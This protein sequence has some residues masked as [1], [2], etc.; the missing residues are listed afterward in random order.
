M[1]ILLG[2]ATELLK[3]PPEKGTVLLLF[4]SA[5]ETGAGAKSVMESGILDGFEIDFAFALHNVPG[6]PEGTIVCK[7]GIFTPAV[8]SVTVSLSGKT[9]HAGE[10]DNGVNPS[11][12]ISRLIQYFNA[13]HHPEKGAETYFVSAPIHIAMGEKAFGTSAGSGE[14]SYTLRTY[15]NQ[16]FNLAK[17]AVEK[18]VFRLAQLEKGL[19]FSV[20]WI[21]PFHANENNPVAFEIIREASQK[22]QLP[23]LLKETPFDWGED[24]GLFT[25]K[26]PGAMF[27]LGSGTECPPLHHPDYNFPDVIT[28]YGIRMFLEIST[29]VLA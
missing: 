5:E 9:S 8:E 18:E 19:D 17:S 24:F 16:R 28:P 2:L 1:T 7:P 26:F 6:Y 23:F 27:G 21:E 10:P 22:C 25:T 13:L 3:N 12:A 15:S 4:Q 11:A 14:I 20:A 29:L